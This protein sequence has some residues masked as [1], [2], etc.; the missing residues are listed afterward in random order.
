MNS[1]IPNAALFVVG[2]FVLIKVVRDINS[3]CR[4]LAAEGDALRGWTPFGLASF[5]L[6]FIAVATEY[7]GTKEEEE[8]VAGSSGEEWQAVGGDS[9]SGGGQAMFPGPDLTAD[10]YKAGF[11]LV[12]VSTN[13]APWPA[14]PPDA[15]RHEPWTRFGLAED[16]FWLPATNWSFVL[17]TNAADGA[18]VS[19][20]G[21][22]S[23]WRPKGSPRAV[24]LPDGHAISFLAPLQGWFGTVPPD[25]KFWC[26]P[27]SSN[28]VRFTW[29]HV[30]AGR[31]TN[32][33][34]TFQAELFASG[35]FVYRYAFTNALSLTNFVV[36]AQHG[37]GGETFALNDTNKLVNG[38]ELRWRAFGMLDPGI[39]D[40]DGDGLSTYDEVMVYGTSPSMPDTD[41]DGMGDLAEVV[42]LADPRLRD[43][44]G[45]GMPD[46][47]DPHPTTADPAADGD[48][49]GLPDV[50]ESYWFGSTNAT[51]GADADANGNG[52]ENLAD[53]LTG[54]DPSF[55]VCAVTTS[56][57]E[58]LFTWA[59][60]A[61]ATNYAASVTLGGET[62]W[63]CVT[64]GS[65]LSVTGDFTAA[66]HALSVTAHC[67]N[68]VA[69]HTASVTFRQPS[70]PNLTVWKIAP[71]FALDPPSDN[72]VVMER[73]F[74]IG[75]TGEWQRFFVS[76]GHESAAPW[77]LEGLRLEWSD[78]TGMA[79]TNSASPSGDSLPLDVGPDAQTLTVRL[80]T[81]RGTGTA[82]SPDTL[83]LIGWSPAVTFGTNAAFIA[84]ESGP[85]LVTVTGMDNSPTGPAFSVDTAGRPHNA[86]MADAEIAALSA[87]FGT[88]GVPFTGSYANGLLTGGTFNGGAPGSY[89]SDAPGGGGGGGI[90]GGGIGGGG[91]VQPGPPR[92]GPVSF[93]H[94]LIAPQILR[95]YESQTVGG[96][97]AF[98]FED[99]C[100]RRAFGWGEERVEKGFR[101]YLGS[102]SLDAAFSVT[103]S[104]GAGPYHAWGD[105]ESWTH[106]DVGI[107]GA[108]AL[109]I[110]V[111][112]EPDGFW[113]QGCDWSRSG[114]GCGCEGSCKTC[115]SG[116]DESGSV[117]FRIPLGDTGYNTMAGYVWFNVESNGVAVSP[118]I[119]SVTGDPTVHK[120]F[121]TG[122]LSRVYCDAGAGGRDI[123]IAVTDNGVLVSV[124]DYSPAGFSADYVWEITN[125][126]G[127]HGKVLF[128]KKVGEVTR[129][130]ATHEFSEGVW[131]RTDGI[132]GLYETSARTGDLLSWEWEENEHC[133]YG[134]Q[135]GARVSGQ[136]IRK[137]L[138]G[139]GAVPVARVTSIK[140][141]DGVAQ[142]WRETQMTYWQDNLNELLNGCPKFKSDGDGSWEYLAYDG[143]GRE[144]LR[145]EPLDGSGLPPFRDAAVPFAL[146]DAGA[147]GAFT[148]RVTV[149]GYE[150]ADAGSHLDSRRPRTVS[151]YAVRNGDITLVSKEWHTYTRGES[152]EG[153]VTLTHRVTRAASQAADIN[154]A[155]NPWT[156]TVTYADDDSLTPVLLRGRTLREESGDGSL[157]TWA[158]D[159]DDS[160]PQEVLKVTARRATAALPEGLSNV[161]TLSV[162]TLD[163]VFGRILSRETR[164]VSGDGS[165]R[166]SL[167]ERGYDEKGRL[168]VTVYSDGTC[169]SNEWDCCLMT[170]AVARDGTRREFLAE[171]DDERWKSSSD[172]SLGSLP[173]ADG[174]YPVTETF[175]DAIGRETNS[176]RYVSG[177]SLAPLSTRTDY[178][179]GTDN[180]RV[181]TDPLGVRTVSRTYYG[182]NCEIGETVTAGV[183][184]RTTKYWGGATVEEKYWDG[185][186]TRETRATT[187]DASGC[188]V[189][190]VTAEAS[191]MPAP[192]VTSETVYDFLGREVSVATPLSVTSNFY[193]GA[194]DRVI[195]VSRTGSP[196]TLY[197]YDDVGELAATALD[198]DG[199]GQVSH[200]GTDR[201]SATVTRYEEDVSNI[202]WRVT[203]SAESV[204]GVTNSASE[205]RE[206]LT[207]LSPALLS[208]T[209]TADARNVT[210]T[211]TAA[212][213]TETHVVTETTE[214]PLQLTPTVQMSKYGYALETQRR[215]SKTANVY[216]GFARVETQTSGTQEGFTN[217]VLSIVYDAVGQAVTNRMSYGPNEAVDA[218]VYDNRGRAVS[219]TDALGNTVETAYDSLGQALSLSGATYP[220][221]YV[222]DTAG[223]M[224]A[225][226]TTRDGV[227]WD[228]TG[229]LYDGATGLLTNKVYADGSRVS[230]TY[231]PQGKLASRVWARGVTMAN[232]YDLL[233]QIIWI[234][235][236]GDMYDVFHAYD[237]FGHAV[238]SSNSFARYEYRNSLSGIVT[239][240]SVTVGTNTCMLTR[241]LDAHDRRVGLR[242]DGSEAA[243]GYDEENRVT[244]VSHPEA[245]AEYRYANG[246]VAGYTLTLTNGNA[247]ERLVVRD[248]Y[249]QELTL[250]V[251][252]RFNGAFMQ[253]ADYGHDLLGRRERRLDTASGLSVTNTF[254]YNL[255]SEITNAVFGADLYVY[256]Y[257]PIGNR[258]FYAVNAVTN[259]YSANNLNQYAGLSYDADGNLLSDG[260][261]TFSWDA[262]NRLQAVTPANA[263]N[264]SLKVVNW[265]DHRHRRVTKE[266][267]ELSGYTPPY[268][269]PPMPGDPG[270]WNLL[271]TH[272]FFYD[273]W[274][275]AL[276]TVAHTNGSVDRI[277]YV[278]GLDLSGTLQGAGGV[279]GLLFEKRNGQIYIPLYDANGNVT[280][281]VDANGTV[282][283]HFECDAFGNT[284]AMWGDLAH[285][286][287]FRFST[288]Y[289]D[290]ETRSYYYGYRHYAPKLGCWLSRDPIEENGGKNVYG[291]LENEPISSIDI[292]G[293]HDYKITILPD[294]EV[295]YVLKSIEGPAGGQTVGRDTYSHA[296]T[297]D[298]D[299]RTKKYKP[300]ITLKITLK[301]YIVNEGV[302]LDGRGKRTSKGVAIT[303]AHENLHKKKIKEKI[304]SVWGKYKSISE[305]EY[306][307][308]NL[309]IYNLAKIY[310]PIVENLEVEKAYALEFDHTG[311]HWIEFFDTYGREATW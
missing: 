93:T 31:D 270:E 124:G 47:S 113:P 53:L 109:G 72:A 203:S 76:A 117:R 183:T 264:G 159:Y 42:S 304:E 305:N 179:Y 232:N 226:S 80:V 153:Y 244:G 275:L 230:Y 282:R 227:A 205:V 174:H 284:V 167:E 235:Y 46:G 143:R 225:L 20:D 118:S 60:L 5:L 52:A 193:E 176:V 185:K 218:T 254:G 82:R 22:L 18:H 110:D 224:T 188:R 261:H 233:G 263:T 156:E 288:K 260:E 57:G 142:A 1:P 40:H 98:P 239:N 301:S 216:D 56:Q 84:T 278:W 296:I 26:A 190:T 79:G 272:T 152:A 94:Y 19:S 62:V 38:L 310:Q 300:N 12:S 249:R 83:N 63:T 192:V 61:D 237:A 115:K 165:E 106:M 49:D 194:S 217:S 154:S 181:T 55:A 158:Y 155:G 201:I 234:D 9:L 111:R 255:R 274:N 307:S 17:G 125:P 10:Q 289:W 170:A 220:V 309:C 172:V 123:R 54:V 43:T 141:W 168:T 64:N 292:R 268:G 23:F 191:D 171:P 6:L 267:F 36:G 182:N 73:T 287:K 241:D 281:Y 211:V 251:S 3:K 138:T 87:P 151:G 11:A 51:G 108:S 197:V 67:T 21:T 208:R 256:G 178:P 276:E 231:T 223:R 297:C 148:A 257:D 34:V 96:C 169:E 69:T 213:D 77:A 161:S 248:P 130:I 7:A 196:D 91:G 308:R 243:Y 240:E 147:Y 85:V 128:V 102:E 265:Y 209:V 184:N 103:N 37:G 273:G 41:L 215:D 44:D 258:V 187:H 186:W 35:D 126:N 66:G 32:S 97:P 277:E 250:A 149:T 302:F 145:A 291:F 135:G 90:G 177:A 48:G 195:R 25:G 294:D 28:S 175:A 89:A 112:R 253:A 228:T 95:E 134:S 242:V 65:S 101:V 259:I 88:E 71:P 129:K 199:N 222:Y 221:A 131:S 92:P 27:T 24:E 75:R 45:D 33:P 114:G 13:A 139:S 164:V 236:S 86:A 133:I 29:Q 271:R 50:W 137:T 100:D 81:T 286:F 70:L 202:W 16:T 206:Q 127:E 104:S 122:L 166:L 146:A 105:G 140:E 229:W 8:S 157:A 162:E 173:G 293:L 78:D 219:R 150:G 252:N 99:P 290:D 4:R 212:M 238:A 59:A 207:G 163:T 68:A 74:W 116:G 144:T 210:T 285:T 214:N 306:A 107:S 204:G 2:L 39:D 132:T 247:V 269:E 58:H 120:E 266:V 200:E 180:Y 189:E 311:D 136:I 245:A 299:K 262:E 119:F 279:G 283:G 280:A 121:T 295:N 14:E 160:G 303:K 246:F 15:V 30:F 198:V 298:C